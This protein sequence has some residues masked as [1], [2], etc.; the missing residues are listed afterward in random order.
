MKSLKRWL[1]VLLVVLLTSMAGGWLGSRLGHASLQKHADFHAAVLRSIELTSTQR[2][3]LDELEVRHTAEQEAMREQ[4]RA[5][6]AAL[7]SVLDDK[8]SYDAE[9][10]A[11]INSNHRLLGAL[12][13]LTL[14][15]LF[16]MRAVLD[17][18]QQVE[19]DRLVALSLRD[20]VD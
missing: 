5:A 13:Q 18:G 2:R 10:E 12:Q 4:V 19:F 1:P 17:A 8:S 3:A 7:A 11:A 16:E 20:A 9:V 14:R 15:Q 6:T